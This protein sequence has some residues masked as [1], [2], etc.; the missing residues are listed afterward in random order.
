MQRLI[1]GLFVIGSIMIFGVVGPAEAQGHGGGHGGGGHGGGHAVSGGHVTG[2]HA[3]AGGHV[4]VGHAV[5]RAGGHVVA[6]VA[7]HGYRSTV[8]PHIGV[9]VG[10]GYY[11]G[12]GYGHPYASPYGYGYPGYYPYGS[13]DYPG[14]Y[15][16]TNAAYGGLRIVGAPRNAAVYVDGYYVG[17]VDNFDGVFQHLDLEPGPHRVEIQAPGNPPLTVDVNI[18]PGRTITYRA[19]RQP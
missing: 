18:Q 5:P 19:D 10:Y 9:G 6:P 2:G 13:Y 17:I 16:G 1:G 12:L 8:L 4:A 3:V 7:P 11:S 15:A 14:Y